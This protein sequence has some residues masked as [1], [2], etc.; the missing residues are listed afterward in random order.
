MCRQAAK[1]NISQKYRSTH[2]PLHKSLFYN[3]LTTKYIFGTLIV[4]IARRIET[5][6]NNKKTKGELSC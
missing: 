2:C 6:K 3:N 4:L 1:L 5:I